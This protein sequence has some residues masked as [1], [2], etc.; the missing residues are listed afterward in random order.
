MFD[1]QTLEHHAEQGLD[2]LD[3]LLIPMHTALMYWPAVM[4]TAELVYYIQQGQ[5]I[6]VPN[7]PTSG[8]VKLF[9]DKPSSNNTEPNHFLGI[10]EVLDDGRIAPRRIINV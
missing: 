5:P 2:A 10:G 1:F 3:N 8:W 9:A 6:Q 7:A 4:L